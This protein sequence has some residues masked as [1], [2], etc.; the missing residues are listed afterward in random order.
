MRQPPAQGFL[1]W[2][3][4]STAPRQWLQILTAS[5][6]RGQIPT[7]FL[8][9]THGQVL[10]WIQLHRA[11]API[12]HRTAVAEL[13][14]QAARSIPGCPILVALGVGT[15]EKE[16]LF[17]TP[18]TGSAPQNLTFVPIDASV[19]L[20]LEAC[21]LAQENL[22]DLTILPVCTDLNIG[23]WLSEQAQSLS[24]RRLWLCFGIL[25]NVL[26]ELFTARLARHLR[27]GD[28]I[29]IGT[30]LLPPQK[31]E[32]IFA[33]YDHPLTRNW[34]AL[35]LRELNCPEPAALRF[36]WEI[37]PKYRRIRS[38]WQGAQPW[39]AQWLDQP[40]ATI[41]PDGLEVFASNRF[42]PDQVINLFV[43]HGLT[44][45]EHWI[46]PEGEEGLFLFHA[47]A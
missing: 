1:I 39:T 46:D 47:A 42:S 25:P 11:L 5:L 17:L 32:E 20:L 10:A 41:K 44:H 29:L 8:Y 38:I 22:P 34:L 18:I 23:A 26:P 28:L 16:R 12:H 19:G 43:G 13:Y 36:S 3:D 37:R 27:P 9:A 33:Q 2:H 40:L 35:A 45:S 31:D 15:G 14:H 24:G 21:S 4:P 7:S 6:H 30:N